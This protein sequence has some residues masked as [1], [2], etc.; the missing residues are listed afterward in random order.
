[1]MINSII[2]LFTVD[3]GRGIEYRLIRLLDI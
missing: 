1:M 3:F 2:F